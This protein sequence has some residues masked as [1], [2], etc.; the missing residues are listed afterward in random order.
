MFFPDYIYD[1]STSV[2]ISKVT[3]R[4]ERVSAISLHCSRGER[5]ALEA[6]ADSSRRY[7]VA[8]AHDGFRLVAVG[9]VGCAVDG[10]ET[11][12]L[13]LRSDSETRTHGPSNPRFSTH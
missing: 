6:L 2:S 4:V 5:L 9:A 1:V 8:D 11:V 13:A 3:A 10:V 12:V 7:V